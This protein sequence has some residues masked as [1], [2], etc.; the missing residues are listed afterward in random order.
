MEAATKLQRNERGTRVHNTIRLH[1]YVYELQ[2]YMVNLSG[3]NCPRPWLEKVAAA[4]PQQHAGSV[5]LTFCCHISCEICPET[6]S[7]VI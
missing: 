7:A 1:E 3:A 5:M 6:F 2:P 4:I